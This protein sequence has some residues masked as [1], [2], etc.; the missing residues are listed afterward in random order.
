MKKLIKKYAV[1]N[2]SKYGKAEKEAVVGK[3]F[4]EKP[5][6]KEDAQKVLK[7]AD[8]VIEEINS[9][10]KE[11]IEGLK[12]EYRY[13]EE[14]EDE[15]RLPDLPN[16][17]EEE[18]VVMR[19]AP[20]PSG[21][22]HVG[23]ARMAI[24]NDEYVKKYGGKLY[25]VLDD[26]PGS[27][28]KRP[29]EEA[30]E[31]IPKDL[32]WLGID[33]DEIVHKS[34]R[35]ELYHEYA[36]KFLEKGW[37]YVCECEAEKLRE[38]RKKGEECEHRSQSSEE[39]LKKWDKMLNGGYEEGEVAVR[40]K[41]NMQHE[42]PAFRDRVL[43]RISDFEHPRVGQDYQ[44]WP[45]LE[46]CW[47]VDDHKLGMTH[48][49]RGKDLM[50]ENKMEKYMWDLLDWEHPQITNHG[51]MRIEGVKMSKSTSRKKIE[52]GEYTGWEDPRTW[53]LM[54]L[55]KRGFKPEAIRNFYISFGISD[56]DAS[57][58]VDSLYT[59]NRKLVDEEADRYFFVE[60][61]KEIEVEGIED[62]KVAKADLH[63]DN[64]ERGHR[65][66][67]V[68]PEEGKTKILIEE[69]DYDEGK[70]LRLKDLF[71]VR[72]ED[73]KAEIVNESLEYAL[74]NDLDIVQWLPENDKK[75]CHILM[76]DGKEKKGYCESNIEEK[77]QV[78]Q[79]IR[80]G[81][82]RIDEIVKE[83]VNCYFTHH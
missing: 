55:R 27:E 65:E 34:D 47:A 75:E 6:L 10:S 21:M 42:D 13:P 5:E 69:D 60:E 51:M 70:E 9:L 43:L 46:F 24:L 2:A 79:F 44:V 58:P 77:D 48:I 76:P 22:L 66:I 16:A 67:E 63:P 28:E 20:A 81:F 30:Y 19:I 26:T 78:V 52:E 45:M 36:E 14:E 35:V 17:S 29:M 82:C 23:N 83:K 32:E 53:S 57:V 71:N 31:K 80:F 59:E 11:E 62:K 72:L 49:L 18:G 41:T 64:P 4:A 33:F 39:N 8:N 7:E 61:P 56:T 12:E 74:D 73:G 68:E 38:N 50:M 40:L 1:K 15:E 3:V 37:A 54:S 25:L